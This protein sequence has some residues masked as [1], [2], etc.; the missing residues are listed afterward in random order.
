M[1]FLGS[2][3]PDVARCSPIR[4]A[5]YDVRCSEGGTLLAPARTE[6]CPVAEILM[7]VLAEALGA[8][9]LALVVA[10]LKRA[11]GAARA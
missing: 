9:L 10:G 8:A 11:M 4:Q 1:P 6:E 7:S 3:T 5:S 2:S